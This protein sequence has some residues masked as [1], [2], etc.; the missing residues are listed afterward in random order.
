M[1]LGPWEASELAAKIQAT[2][3]AR[4]KVEFT[5][6]PHK[7]VRKT[8]DAKQE[9]EILTTWTIEALGKDLAQFSD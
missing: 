6:A 5:L 8:K 4:D 9:E 2:L 1:C 3:D 7:F